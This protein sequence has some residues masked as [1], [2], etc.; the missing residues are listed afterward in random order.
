MFTSFQLGRLEEEMRSA[1]PLTSAM[2]VRLERVDEEGLHLTAPLEVNAN[3]QGTVFGG[4][5][6]ALGILAGW[7][8]VR[9]CLR[10]SG[11]APTLVIQ[12]TRIEFLEPAVGDLEAVAR[13]PDEEVWDRFLRTFRRRGRSRVAIEIVLRVDREVVAELTGW[14]VAL[15]DD[16]A[17]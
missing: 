5:A 7:S 1:I 6:A 4:S 11:L 15:R 13:S 14:Y 16:E 8:M 9:L 3:V 10:E 12:R 2:G 17:A